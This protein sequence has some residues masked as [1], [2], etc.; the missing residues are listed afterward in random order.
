[1]LFAASDAPAVGGS[2]TASYDLFRR[3]IAAGHDAHYAALLEEDDA[4]WCELALQPGMAN[5]AGLPNVH[6]VR[7]P[8]SARRASADVAR[9]INDV[10]PDAMA[11]FG[12]IASQHL[13]RSAPD[14]PVAYVTGTCRQA[15]DYVT[16]GWA[17]DATD[18]QERLTR[19]T[20]NPRIVHDGEASAVELCDVIIT[21]SRLTLDMMTTFFPDALGKIWP[22]VVSFADWIADGARSSRHHARPFAERDIDVLFIATNWSRREKNYPLVDALVKQLDGASVHIVGDVPHRVEGATHHGFLGDRDALFAIMGRARCVACPSLI[23]AAPGILFEASVLGC[24]AVASRNCGNW[25]ICH[26]DLLAE[27]L[28]AN[29]MAACIRRA[30]QRRYDDRL[31]AHPSHAFGELLSVLGALGRPIGRRPAT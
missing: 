31:A 17:R 4:T 14:H 29:S 25:D 26:P 28:G 1:M 5:P 22:D 13:K 23:D 7:V 18:L 2:A 9:L 19:G 8:R 27:Q 16:A 20:L 3:A 10:R 12:F 24:N 15:Q 6:M 21:H 11:G 30:V